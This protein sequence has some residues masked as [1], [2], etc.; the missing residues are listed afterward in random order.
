MDGPLEESREAHDL[1]TARFFLENLDP[2]CGRL[3]LE[4]EEHHHASKVLRLR[5]GEEVLVLDG[6][7]T[8]YPSVVSSVESRRTWLEILGSYHEE[9]ELPRLVLYQALLPSSRMEEAIRRCVELGVSEVIPFRCRRSLGKDAAG[10]RERWQR[11]AR[12][13]ARVAGRSYLPRIGEVLEWPDL[14]REV[15]DRKAILLADE[16]G[17]L[18]PSQSIGEDRPPEIALLTGPAGGFE[19]EERRALLS[20]GAVSV[21]L[22]KL[23]LRAESAGAVLLAVVKAHLGLM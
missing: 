23:N 13:S 14:L 9:E 7:G 18:K 15:R 20:A 10:R 16:R 1:T 19:D 4:K 12:D 11:V 5:P 3:A 8:I 17:G 6:K 21:T 22:G 2:L